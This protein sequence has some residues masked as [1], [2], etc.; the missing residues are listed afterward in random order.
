VILQP[1][2]NRKELQ[3]RLLDSRNNA[4]IK[5]TRINEATGEEVPWND[6]VKA[7]EFDDS[8]FVVVTDADF[9]RAAPKASRT[10]E[11]EQ[12]VDEEEVS[13][14]YFDTPYYL[15][16]DKNGEKGYALLREA[17]LRTKKVGVARVVIRT[18]E[19][20]SLLRA[21][22][23]CLELLLLRFNQELREIPANLPS[24]KEARV[25]PK[26]LDMAMTLVDS[27][28]GEW[29]PEEY[30]NKYRDELMKWIEKKAKSGGVMPPATEEEEEE[31]PAGK[32]INFAELL[33]KS[34]HQKGTGKPAGRAHKSEIR[35]GGSTPRRKTG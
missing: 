9:K 23:L 5:Y 32:I 16:P 33:K 30:H 10:V 7:Y 25:Q 21:D 15:E 17:L 19:Y 14:L 20:L 6:V 24:L 34:L 13:P 29:K 18:R 12:F 8:N 4:R 31:Y 35:R 22:E 28:S 26:E 11:I 2:E 3:F 27:M 1:A